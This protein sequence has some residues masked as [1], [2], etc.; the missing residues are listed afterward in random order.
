M[1]EES[2]SHMAEYPRVELVRD[3]ASGHHSSRGS[4]QRR[5]AAAKAPKSEP[6]TR[7]RHPG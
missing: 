7:A 2:V 3:L 1:P 5:E 6:L 4:V